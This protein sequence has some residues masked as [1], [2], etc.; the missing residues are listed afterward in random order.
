M[1]S[2]GMNAAAGA[3]GPEP[4]KKG[5]GRFLFLMI[6]LVIGVCVTAVIV[7][8]L[9]QLRGGPG[10]A[11]KLEGRGYDTPEEAVFTYAQY[12]KTGDFDGIVSTFAMESYEKNYS[13]K[14]HYD[15]APTFSPAY[16]TGG[17][18]A[19]LF[20]FESELAESINL[21]N[22]RAYIAAGVMRQS[23]IAMLERFGDEELSRNYMDGLMYKISD[24]EERD[25]VLDFLNTSPGFDGMMIGGYL[26][27]SEFDNTYLT[28][29]NIHNK[30]KEKEWGG[31]M[32]NVCM[33][34]EIDG[35]DYVLCMTCVCYDGKW[36]IA[37][38]GNYYSLICNISPIVSG[39]CPAAPFDGLK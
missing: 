24:D 18:L 19:V 6:G 5:T 1:N 36:Y 23:I 38:F 13:V 28:G 12:L 30:G 31:D 4:R 16:V 35:K 27:A 7:L 14:E 25:T 2:N 21:E 3:S 20:G 34:L 8:V 29:L 26:D 39:L 37:E 22:R 10:K 15:R 17:Q 33:E 9:T 32:E 11:A